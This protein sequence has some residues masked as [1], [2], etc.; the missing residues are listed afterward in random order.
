ML[1]IALVGGIVFLSGALGAAGPRERLEA[2]FAPG[3]RLQTHYAEQGQSA[4]EAFNLSVQLTA[5]WSVLSSTGD[6]LVLLGEIEAIDIS[7]AA[8]MPAEET[9]AERQRP[10]DSKTLA[11]IGKLK[12][13][14]NRSGATLETNVKSLVT[15]GELGFEADSKL[16]TAR[17]NFIRDL[18]RH[19]LERA[20]FE[21]FAD[22]FQP[23]SGE[24]IEPKSETK[25]KGL[26]RLL[27]YPTQERR[28]SE[29]AGFEVT[30]GPPRTWKVGG[31]SYA[32]AKAAFVSGA[33]PKPLPDPSSR[34][35]WGEKGQRVIS[36]EAALSGKDAS[37]VEESVG[38][39]LDVKELPGGGVRIAQARRL[40][41]PGFTVGQVFLFDLV[42]RIQASHHAGGKAVGF[43]RSLTGRI[44]A[45][46]VAG[47]PTPRLSAIFVDGRFRV[48]EGPAAPSAKLFGGWDAV[49]GF[50]LA[51][52]E[53]ELSRSETNAIGV[54]AS[55][56]PIKKVLEPV[57]S[58]ALQGA[59]T[60][61][62]QPIKLSS[63][64]LPAVD[65]KSNAELLID[66]DL[67]RPFR[68][69]DPSVDGRGVKERSFVLNRVWSGAVTAEKRG[70]DPATCFYT[71]VADPIA[72]TPPRCELNVEDELRI[73]PSAKTKASQRSVV[74]RSA[75]SSRQILGPRVE[76]GKETAQRKEDV[77]AAFEPL[78]PPDL[79]PWLSDAERRSLDDF[80]RDLPDG[81]PGVTAALKRYAEVEA[82][83][84]GSKA[85][86]IWHS[87]LTQKL[88]AR[89]GKDAQTA[90]ASHLARSSS[91]PVRIL[92]MR[93]IAYAPP[94]IAVNEKV[95]ALAPWLGDSNL[96]V[97]RLAG[98]FLSTLRAPESIEAL[99]AALKAREGQPDENV[100]Q[101]ELRLSFVADLFR[102]L[103]EG[104]RTPTSKSIEAIWARLEKKVPSD[105]LDPKAAVHATM[106]DAYRAFGD[107]RF[108]PVVFVLDASSSMGD[109]VSTIGIPLPPDPKGKAIPKTI[110]KLEW[111][112]REMSA[113]L[114]D[115]ESGTRIN[116]VAFNKDAWGFREA[117][118]GLTADVLLEADKLVRGIKSSRGTNIHAGFE[119]AFRSGA[120][121]SI[122][123]FT[124]GSP[125]VGPEPD[126][127]ERTVFHRNYLSGAR[128][129]V[130][131]FLDDVA[132][133]ENLCSRL[134]REHFGW[135]RVLDRQ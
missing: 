35:L 34:L 25:A 78:P 22:V 38:I 1:R 83:Q 12:A 10:I 5:E 79:K 53:L 115:L 87:E 19:L 2:L 126:E 60:A 82:P 124:D 113:V 47:G 75:V 27:R 134:A 30:I 37:D 93:L 73:A 40:D 29:P 98:R 66:V 116:I 84:E 57:L 71:V 131:S 128:I 21:S 107:V 8:Q 9:R 104:V 86:A 46:V 6:S 127:I 76:P 72:T 129:V 56:C 110:S 59:F 62:S 132:K 123:L 18:Q 91:F 7:I 42:H 122:C 103:G 85:G 130:A 70:Q 31:L 92:A 81:W 51:G 108:P 43:K 54:V 80:L 17:Y 61:P 111:V 101:K 52:I 120:A 77:E 11:R 88:A 63:V 95:A 23:L 94:L 89:V 118:V 58:E 4:G 100:E 90:L 36:W 133:P 68:E 97:A 48:L 28:R 119:S 15:L 69:V 49:E 45:S 13:S 114:A 33:K 39:T 32:G 50:G 26:R 16:L 55:E 64:R 135:V 74:W 14:V 109:S 102:L 20:I 41:L 96:A 125:T 121:G 67:T 24:T 112:G 3:C 44:A 106:V 105:P 99:L 65:G 117:P